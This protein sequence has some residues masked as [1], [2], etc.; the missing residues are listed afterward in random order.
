VLK[1][2]RVRKKPCIG[3]TQENL[4]I[5]VQSSK[6]LSDEATL[7]LSDTRELDRVPNTK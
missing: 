7:V 6:C 4:I 2:V 1:S 5:M 3:I